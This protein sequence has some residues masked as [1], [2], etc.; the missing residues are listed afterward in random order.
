MPTIQVKTNLDFDEG[1]KRA[2]LSSVSDIVSRIAGK[3][4][5][6]IMVLMSRE[7]F[8]MGGTFDPAAFVD[9]RHVSP[10][11]IDCMRELCADLGEIF[12]AIT[13]ISSARIYIQFSR[14]GDASAWRFQDGV[15]SC[16]RMK[17]AH[18]N[19]N[20]NSDEPDTAE[21]VGCD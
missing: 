18:G 7:D 12:S 9:I 16:P 10:L 2:I 4:H 5:C 21:T 3:P 8:M 13:R 19:K 20:E 6:D 14:V 17:N 11:G 15:A 1:V